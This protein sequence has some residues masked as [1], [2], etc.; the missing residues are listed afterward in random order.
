[1]DAPEASRHTASFG[2]RAYALVAFAASVTM[3][4]RLWEGDLF[5]DEVLYAAVAK[6]IVE[7]GEWL[8]LYIGGDPYWR[9]PP[10]M[11]WLA[12]GMYQLAG[13]SV[14]SAKLF[15]ALCGVLSCLALY[16]L[17]RRFFGDRVALVAALV[18][19]TTPRFVRTSATFR[20]DSGVALFTLLALLS[21]VRAVADS[22][23]RA[24][25]AAGLFWG[26]AVMAKGAFGLA[27]PYLFLL[28]LAVHRRLPV[29]LSG[30]FIGSVVIGA[31]VCLPWHLYEIA[32]WGP[33]FLDV[34]LRE[35]V[36]DRLSGRMLPGGVEPQSYLHALLR[37]DWLW[38]PFL[39]FGSVQAARRARTGDRN[40]LYALVWAVG[41][42]LLLYASEGRR[43]R[44]LTQFYPAAAVLT[45]LGVDRVLPARW[46]PH[47]PR[48]ALGLF[49]TAAF[50]LL[51]LPVPIHTSAATDLKAL[52]PALEV[53]APGSTAALVGYRTPSLNLRAACLF[54]LDR[55]LHYVH[56][57]ER[58][59]HTPLAIVLTSPEQSRT[60]EAAGFSPAYA[61]PSFVLL[62]RLP[63][64]RASPAPGVV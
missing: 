22:E 46:T 41:Y 35:Q 28:Y 33:G 1:M 49:G 15:P 63:V 37:D 34:Y 6:G 45:A 50:G 9:K 56:R 27:A 2:R 21:Y 30:G 36:V 61:N 7:R 59:P 47:L 3:L 51:V 58:I 13:I 8:D 38:L 25:A 52:R 10:L 32:R 12:A 64:P 57:P 20:L 48:A 54:Y 23:R 44:Y 19:A 53:L 39:A 24:F 55:D 11:F 26:L 5:R 14:F 18:L 29:L 60:L 31:V 62:R 16:A 40:A 42:L 4:S 43:A 17:V